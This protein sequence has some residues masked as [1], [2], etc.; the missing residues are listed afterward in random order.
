[1]AGLKRGEQ[2]DLIAC[3]IDEARNETFSLQVLSHIP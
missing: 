1:M 2:L 3:V